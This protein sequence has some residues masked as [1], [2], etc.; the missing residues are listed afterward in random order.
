MTPSMQR[1]TGY[2]TQLDNAVRFPTD[3]LRHKINV[4]SLVGLVLAALSHRV[5]GCF[6]TLA[7]NIFDALRWCREVSA[8]K[9]DVRV[10][11][12]GTRHKALMSCVV[13]WAKA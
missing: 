3:P 13:A 6:R 2:S 7:G 1:A 8:F 5:L 9:L 12:R 10:V 11:E 4:V